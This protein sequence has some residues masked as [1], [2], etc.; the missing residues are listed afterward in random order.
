[1]SD[2]AQGYDPDT[3]I[4]EMPDRLF[5]FSPHM[6]WQG[7]VLCWG[8]GTVSRCEDHLDA[9]QFSTFTPMQRRI[10]AARLTALAQEVRP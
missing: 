1:M 5:L 7:V 4:V 9:D 2:E 6:D 10:M 3:G 8:N